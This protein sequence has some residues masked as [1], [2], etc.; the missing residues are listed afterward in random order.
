MKCASPKTKNQK[1]K[2]YRHLFGGGRVLGD[3]LG[4][5]RHGVLGKLTRQDESYTAETC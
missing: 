1:A 3:G 2:G 4:T 5:L